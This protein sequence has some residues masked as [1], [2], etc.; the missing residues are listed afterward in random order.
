MGFFSRRDK[1]GYDKN[2]YW[3]HDKIHNYMETK[4]SSGGYD[5]DGVN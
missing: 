1:Y 3:E 2:G 4:Y 5:R